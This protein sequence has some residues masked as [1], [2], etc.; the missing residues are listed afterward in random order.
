MRDSLYYMILISL[1]EFVKPFSADFYV[2]RVQDVYNLHD[3]TDYI[4]LEGLLVSENILFCSKK[5]W[6]FILN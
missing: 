2:S 3:Y 1:K 4:T 6:F 5:M